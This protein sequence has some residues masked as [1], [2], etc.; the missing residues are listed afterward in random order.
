L[1]EAGI[2]DEQAA[3][4]PIQDDVYRGGRV[5][6]ERDGGQDGRRGGARHDLERDQGGHQHEQQ[7]QRA[8]SR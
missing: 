1:R 7:G 8:A 5:Q 4:A 6:V 2:D 3:G